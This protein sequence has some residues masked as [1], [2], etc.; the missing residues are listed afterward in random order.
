[1]GFYYLHHFQNNDFVL[2]SSCKPKKKKH[3]FANTGQ[4]VLRQKDDT[5]QF[6]SIWFK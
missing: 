1:M 4:F 5:A 3:R 6:I 2:S